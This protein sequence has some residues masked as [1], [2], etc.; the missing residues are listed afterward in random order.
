M[1]IKT[2]KGMKCRRLGGSGLWVSEVGLG[3]WKW[4]V[5]GYDRSRVNDHEGFKILDRALELG[6]FHWDNANSYNWGSGNSERLLGRYFNS[7]PSSVRDMVVL[8]TKITNSVRNEHEMERDFS[9][10]ERG[11]SR[12]YIIQAVDGC[13]ERLRT[14]RIDILYLHSPTLM[15]DGSWETPL[16]E[17]WAA[18]D[19][20]IQQG[21][22]CYLAVSNR[23][24]SRLEEEV[25]ALKKVASNSSHRIIAV[26]NRYNLAER[27]KVSS[28]SQE[29]AEAA[30]KSFLDYIGKQKIGLIPYYPLAAGL[31]TG[32]Y[33]IGNFDETG[34][35]V[36][37]G[38]SSKKEFLTERN[39]E[40][41]EK[42]NALAGRKG[43]SP[44][45][46]AI[47]WLLTREAV[48]SVIAGVTRI[49][50]L[51]DNAKASSVS[52]TEEELQEIDRIS[53]T[54]SGG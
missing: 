42:L 2:F 47:A 9:P 14:D 10:N 29:P 35:I 34:R 22:V 18:M 48:S 41:V 28:S 8:A 23:S 33:R 40:L 36:Q 46:L 27:V 31:L 7:R 54:A 11:S 26:Q 30:E 49:E 5:P 6:I 12:K 25:N 20:L 52:F 45:Q 21:K 37:D 50:H 38:E 16:D 13:L 53:S 43:A 19:A 51:E 32:R 3:M 44:A 4:G 15:E 17:T 39:L 1:E 24:S